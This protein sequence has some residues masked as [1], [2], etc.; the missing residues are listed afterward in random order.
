MAMD[1]DELESKIKEVVW[2]A[3]K[4]DG[5]TKDTVPVC[6]S[7][8][9]VFGVDHGKGITIM[10]D[11]GIEIMRASCQGLK[12]DIRV[13]ENLGELPTEVFELCRGIVLRMIETHMTNTWSRATE[14]YYDVSAE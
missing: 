3:F 10:S 11:T 12:Y 5:S 7:K 1:K 9:H 2:Y 4:G 6:E 14:K 13:S 8:I